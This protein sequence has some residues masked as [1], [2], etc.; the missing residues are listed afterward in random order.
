ML[1]LTPPSEG[2]SSINTV[3]KK[4]K[5]TNFFYN[6]QVKIILDKLN[7]LDD[8]Q[9]QSV[10]GTTPDKS[11]AIHK[12]NLNIFDNECSLAIERYTGVVFKHLDGFDPQ[13]QDGNKTPHV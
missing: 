1:I 3:N 10:Y 4:F 5:E 6:N 2:K 8:K 7:Q 9:I 11:T 13:Y 12:N